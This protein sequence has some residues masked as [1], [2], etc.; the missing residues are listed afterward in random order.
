MTKEIETIFEELKNEVI[1]L[2]IRREVFNQLGKNEKRIELL[3]RTGSTVFY[4]LQQNLLDNFQLTLTKLI[5]DRGNNKLTIDRLMKSIKRLNVPNLINALENQ[6][7]RMRDDCETIKKH[8][9]HAIAHINYLVRME[10][11]TNPLSAVSYADIE[12]LIDQLCKFM[13]TIDTFFNRSE[14]LY[15]M[16]SLLGDGN[17]LVEWLKRGLRHYEL[18]CDHKIHWDDL[19]KSEYYNV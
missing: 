1:W 15:E 10:P 6:F 2:S 16:T 11:N 13:N 3:N 18:E 7:S 5:T 17:E 12:N 19:Q 4:I 8:R 9:D 14:T